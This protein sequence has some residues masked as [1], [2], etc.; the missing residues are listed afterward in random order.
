MQEDQPAVSYWR[1]YEGLFIVS[2]SKTERPA[3]TGSMFPAVL[4][5]LH[6]VADTLLYY[7]MKGY[8]PS[9]D[10]EALDT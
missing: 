1:T 5:T 10:G 2:I 8:L 3:Y 9:K 4:T 6:P 7:V